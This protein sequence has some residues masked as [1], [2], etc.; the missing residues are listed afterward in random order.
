MFRGGHL[1]PPSTVGDHPD[2]TL[3]EEKLPMKTST[4]T[5]AADRTEAGIREPA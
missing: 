2:T 1:G 5:L 4:R 3:K